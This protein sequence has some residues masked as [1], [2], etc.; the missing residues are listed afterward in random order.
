MTTLSVLLGLA[1]LVSAAAVLAARRPAH[2]GIALGVNG[3][4]LATITAWLGASLVAVT[5]A[6][7]GAGILCSA[8]VIRRQRGRETSPATIPSG[9]FIALGAALLSAAM[10]M[11]GLIV[12]YAPGQVG[13]GLPLAASG[14]VEGGLAAL[15]S[16]D[17]APGAVAIAL[18]VVA[19]LL[20]LRLRG[21][22]P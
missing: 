13:A 5:W 18:I 2:A 8:L 4:L 12:H 6:L 19:T 22:E 17:Y 3:L 10:L 14:E 15:L 7:L 9:K 11:G 1:A 20:G 16:A 21:G